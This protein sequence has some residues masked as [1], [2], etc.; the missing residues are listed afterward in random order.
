MEVLTALTVKNAVLQELTLFWS[1]TLV[2]P[3][4]RFVGTYYF[5]P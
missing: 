4:R 1:A 5:Q 3:Y 2:D